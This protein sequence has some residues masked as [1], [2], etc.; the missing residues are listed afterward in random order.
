MVPRVLPPAECSYPQGV[1][2]HRVSYRQRFSYLWGGGGLLPV[3]CSNPQG[4]PT[5][6]GAI[7]SAECS[8]P[9]CVPS[10]R[11]STR[12]GALLL[13][14]SPT[15]G[16]LLPFG[17]SHSQGTSTRRVHLSISVRSHR[18]V[19][20]TRRVHS[21]LWGGGVCYHLRDVPTRGVPLPVRV[22][23][24]CICGVL[25]PVGCFCPLG[26]PTLKVLLPAGC[27][28][29]S[30]CAPTCG[31]LLPAGCSYLWGAPIPGVLLPVGCFCPWINGQLSSTVRR[32]L[33]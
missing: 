19:A 2:T 30:G 7:S 22:R 23:S 20:P 18:R 26:S 27:L 16:V 24:Y 29:S 15:C 3:E 10:C 14:D 9:R 11:V 4:A 6:Q 13:Q 33:C 32:A 31:V 25:L 17:C 21:Y 8:F 1:I 5:S 12:Q 28:Y